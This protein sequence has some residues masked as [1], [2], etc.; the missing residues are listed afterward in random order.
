MTMLGCADGPASFN[1]EMH[2]RSHSVISCDPIYRYTRDDIADRI[3]ATREKV[4]RQTR[5]NR[6]QFVWSSMIP[7]ED[8]LALMRQSA[9]QRFLDD[10]PDGRSSGRYVAGELPDLPFG[11]DRFELAL[12]SHYLF[13]YGAQLS[14][15][16]HL[17]SFQE[18]LRVAGEVR[19]F[20]LHRLDGVRCG[21]V[22]HVLE[23]LREQ[24]HD[25]T[26]RQVD[27]EFQRG[28]DEMMQ[29]IRRPSQR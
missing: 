16:F 4:I 26:I 12:C 25:A 13:L 14:L 23:T 2:S 18:M 8:Q 9:M 24:G 17:Q 27:Y 3:E 1:A 28:G 22:D 10:Y 19:V 20:P 11:R 5:E 29:V 7:D 6:D 21:H 15:A